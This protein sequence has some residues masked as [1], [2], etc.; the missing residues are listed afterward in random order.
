M[1]CEP[2]RG[3]RC[4]TVFGVATGIPTLLPW[5]VPAKVCLGTA[6]C[7]HGGSSSDALRAA[8][9]RGGV[10]GN[11]CGAALVHRGQRNTG[12]GAP[13]ACVCIASLGCPRHSK[14]AQAQGEWPGPGLH[15]MEPCCER[16]KRGGVWSGRHG[17][18]KCRSW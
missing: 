5:R 3:L 9:A 18:V 16:R 12:Q 2:L 14:F 15:G 11:Q 8:I 4:L 6:C 1:R 10:R 13:V 17:G 7:R